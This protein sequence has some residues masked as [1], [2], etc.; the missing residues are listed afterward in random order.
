MCQGARTNSDQRFAEPKRRW[1]RFA[2]KPSWVALIDSVG[3]LSPTPGYHVLP[4]V[5][6][7]RNMLWTTDLEPVAIGLTI[8]SGGPHVS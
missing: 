2:A 6:L 5:D 3:T 1:P 8:E 4:A 7:G